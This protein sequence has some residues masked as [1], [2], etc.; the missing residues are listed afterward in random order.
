MIADRKP[1]FTDA[2]KVAFDAW[3]K[4]Q[5]LAGD[6]A[7]NP[8]LTRHAFVTAYR[9]GAATAALTAGQ[10]SDAL[11]TFWNA[12]LGHAHSTQDSTAMAVTGAVVEGFAAVVQ[13]LRE[14][15]ASPTLTAA[16]PDLLT[17]LK[18]A[19]EWL[20]TLQTGRGIEAKEALAPRLAAIDA[21]I[22][23]G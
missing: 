11:G 9:A 14:F 1:D 19:R 5:C 12:A 20:I 4:A 16:A 10:L 21:A 23:Q 13:R 7:R 3:W 15:S 18:L 2:E 6:P 17:E 8:Y 22:S